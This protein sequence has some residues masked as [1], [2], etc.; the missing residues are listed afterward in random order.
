VAGDAGISF[1][2]NGGTPFTVA[3]VDVSLQ[4]PLYG[5]PNNLGDFWVGP[6][7]DFTQP[8][9]LVILE[10]RTTA[11]SSGGNGDFWIYVSVPANGTIPPFF[12]F[13][14]INNTDKSFGYLHGLGNIE[15]GPN[16]AGS[17]MALSES[18]I[19]L[20]DPPTGGLVSY[21]NTMGAG[22][23]SKWR[24]TPNI[25]VLCIGDSLTGSLTEGLTQAQFWPY[26]VSQLISGKD[27][28]NVGISGRTALALQ[29][30]IPVYSVLIRPF[31]TNHF[32]IDA[33]TN[34]ISG[35]ADAATA[36]ANLSQCVTAAYTAGAQT[37]SVN[38]CLSR[39]WAAAGSSGSDVIRNAFN[40]LI[41][42]GK[43]GADFVVDYTTQSL[44]SADS[45]WNNLTYFNSDGI[46]L[47]P[48]GQVL[49]ASIIATYF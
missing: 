27:F 21:L 41:L 7:Y 23:I 47:T 37:V 11:D 10:G 26:I 4:S 20:D 13:I 32:H 22:E 36:Y 14:K 6:I 42:A 29:A 18:L 8:V 12:A 39:N 40:A 35:G 15:F 25:L 17:E 34:D 1:A 45:A 16:N 48:A 46:H 49:K 3:G 38:T 19:A 31:T 33:G 9:T 24:L 28:P 43:C 5:G 2:N 30:D 44:L